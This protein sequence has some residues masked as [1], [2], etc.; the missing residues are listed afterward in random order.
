[1]KTGNWSAL[2]EK[3]IELVISVFQNSTIENYF[4]LASTLPT[5]FFYNK[6]IAMKEIEHF[7]QNCNER[8]LDSL[9]LAFDPIEERNYS[10]IKDLLLKYTLHLNITYSVEQFLNKI[11][12]K[13]G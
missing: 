6:D 10:E 5:L 3:D 11:I 7:L 13:D 9:F 4:N 12:R 2:E 1:V 8:H